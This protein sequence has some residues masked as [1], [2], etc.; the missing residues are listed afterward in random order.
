MSFLNFSQLWVE[1]KFPDYSQIT[2]IAQKSGQKQV[3]TAV[4]TLDGPVVLKL[5]NLD[6][7]PERIQREVDA[8]QKVNS[9]RVPQILEYGRIVSGADELLWIREQLVVGE[10]LRERFS[11]GQLSVHEILTLGLHILEALAVVE[12]KK[13]VH[14]DVKP[15]NIMVS[16]G[17][18][19]YLLR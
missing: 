17:G 18:D 9:R 14:R 15:E 8:V 13:I 16:S 3:Y 12:E 11:K 1:R 5:V 6:V 10:N 7:E 19:Y 2:P 4:H